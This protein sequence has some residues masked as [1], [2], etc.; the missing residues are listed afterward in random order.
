VIHPKAFLQP[1]DLDASASE[2]TSR[3]GLGRPSVAQRGTVCFPDES[4]A[5]H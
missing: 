3:P 1:A 5:F 4:V 2:T